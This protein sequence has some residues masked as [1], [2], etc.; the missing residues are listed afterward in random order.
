MCS[1]PLDYY[2]GIAWSLAGLVPAW[3]VYSN[4][5]SGGGGGDCSLFRQS[6]VNKEQCYISFYSQFQLKYVFVILIECN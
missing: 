5:N 6:N 4:S 3:L 2:N 1:L